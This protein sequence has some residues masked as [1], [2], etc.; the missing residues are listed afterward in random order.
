MI[1]RIGYVPVDSGQLMIIDP[2]YLADK[3]GEEWYRRV[4]QF[5]NYEFIDSACFI[6]TGGDGAFQVE[7]SESSAG[8]PLVSIKLPYRS[9]WHLA[10]KENK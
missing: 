5:S 10:K 2:C 4:C 1:K 6:Q 8:C 7:L 9:N 3:L